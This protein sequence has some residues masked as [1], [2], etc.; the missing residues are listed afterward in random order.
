MLGGRPAAAMFRLK[1]ASSTT[2]WEM[3][4]EF[5]GAF[6]EK[7]NFLSCYYAML[8]DTAIDVIVKEAK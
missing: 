8:A 1:T 6:S 7:D 3:A 4:W 2:G 5:W